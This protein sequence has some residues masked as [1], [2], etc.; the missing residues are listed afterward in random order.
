MAVPAAWPVIMHGAMRRIGP[1]ILAVAM[2]VG[3]AGGLLYTWVLDPIENRSS[4]PNS[5]RAR[6]K[7][8]YVTI[9]GDL[10]A[11]EGD[12]PRAEARLAELDIEADGPVL[13]GLMSL[14]F[15]RASSK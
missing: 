9:I 3:L 6:D 2:V 14:A 8:V 12:L 7:L 1:I 10:Y 4:T 13:A 15:L 11:Y 5:L